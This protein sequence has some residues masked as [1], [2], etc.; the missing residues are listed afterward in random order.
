MILQM[1]IGGNVRIAQGGVLT[2]ELAREGGR[3]HLE[4]TVAQM[5]GC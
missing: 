2:K 5:E 3:I 1:L 4:M